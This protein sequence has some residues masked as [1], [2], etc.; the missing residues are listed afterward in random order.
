M[1][2]VDEDEEKYLEE[3]LEGKEQKE[4]NG[5]EMQHD[6]QE[7]S[8]EG[9]V[10]HLDSAAPPPLVAIA[11]SSVHI[12]S[13]SLSVQE[14]EEGQPTKGKKGKGK[15]EKKSKTKK[16]DSDGEDS[17]ESSESIAAPK[18]KVIVQPMQWGLIPFYTKPENLKSGIP[19][20]VDLAMTCCK[21]LVA[22]PSMLNARS[23]TVNTLGS[24]KRLTKKNRCVIVADGYYHL[25]MS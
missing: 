19:F 1:R 11:A 7:G 25:V 2:A 4:G 6:E 13:S 18:T 15:S 12:R 17:A 22:G 24:F 20:A 14:D 16:E 21:G 5:E 9:A 23:E 8:R 10:E 3:H